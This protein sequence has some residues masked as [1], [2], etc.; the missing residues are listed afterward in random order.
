MF[1]RTFPSRCFSGRKRWNS[2]FVLGLMHD[3]ER[4]TERAQAFGVTCRH[5]E[6]I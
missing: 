5:L 1:G 6:P 2:G 3:Y 4:R